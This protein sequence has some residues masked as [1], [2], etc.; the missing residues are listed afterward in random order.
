MGNLGFMELLFVLAF[1]LVP[2]AIGIWLLFWARRVLLG[3]RAELT[4][5]RTG[6]AN[7]EA[8][9]RRLDRGA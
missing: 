9:V 8:A 3:L 1:G 4:A 2:A 5:V 6:L 7:L